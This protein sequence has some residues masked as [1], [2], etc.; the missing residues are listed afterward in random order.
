MRV[1][2]FGKAG[3][4]RSRL[5]GDHQLHRLELRLDLLD[6]R[7]ELRPHDQ[8]QRGGVVDDLR[9]LR[10]REP[11]VD[12]REHD[13]ELPRAKQ[14]LEELGHVLVEDGH[15]VTALDTGGAQCVRHLVRPRVELVRT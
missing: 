10:R 5:G 15:A 2:P 12:G 11:P 8:H 13:P 3:P 6:A 4:V 1:A 7:E 9:D 14:E